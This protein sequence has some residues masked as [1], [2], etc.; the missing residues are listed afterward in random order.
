MIAQSTM[1]ITLES[2]LLGGLSPQ[3]FMRRHW[4]KKPLLVRPAIPRGASIFSR[5]QMFDLAASEDVESRLVVM[6]RD[7]V[8]SLRQGPLKRSAIPALKQS[9]WTLL[10][11]GLD[12]HLPAAR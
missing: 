9:G 5:S 3:K 7:G 1:D 10:V 8:W 11:Q 4:Q 6:L 2:R 12:L